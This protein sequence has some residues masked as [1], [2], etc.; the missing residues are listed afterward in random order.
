MTQ[1]KTQKVEELQRRI[2]VLE[3]EKEKRNIEARKWAEKRDQLNEKVKNLSIEIHKLKNER[4]ELNHEVQKLKQLRDE[5]KTVIHEKIGEFK[6]LSQQVRTLIQQKSSK[7]IQT[8]KK[9]ME[10]I[11]WKIQT[12]SLSLEEERQLV[13]QVQKLGA[14]ITILEKLES[15]YKKKRK[16]QTELEAAKVS[17]QSYH[18]KLM[19]KAQ[20]SQEFH[21]KIGDK[22]DEV[23]KVRVEADNMHRNYVQNKQNIKPIHKEIADISN[24]IELLRKE[25]H[26][27]EEKEKKMV[28]KALRKKLEEQARKKMKGGGKLTWNEFKILSEND[29]TTQD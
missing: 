22:I 2:T 11:E 10:E 17:N 12:T 13:D 29:E 28:E 5:A 8:L 7:E 20:K 25:I 9:K 1:E 18:N 23:K 6:E 19:E 27:D 14:E 26:E 15:L 4:D 21:S 24:K 16:V 3:E